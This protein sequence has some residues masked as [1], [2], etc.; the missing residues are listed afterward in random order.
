MAASSP[1]LLSAA[2]LALR[3]VGSAA[4][5]PLRFNEDSLCQAGLL[6]A[7]SRGLTWAGTPWNPVEDPR[8]PLSR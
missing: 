2:V 1:A 6:I 4:A 3:L 8:G 5:L 7:N